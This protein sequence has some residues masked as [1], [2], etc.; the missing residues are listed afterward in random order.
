[1]E[2]A[3]GLHGRIFHV[4]IRRHVYRRAAPDP[5]DDVLTDAI[6]AFLG[7][8]GCPRTASAIDRASPAPIPI[9]FPPTSRRMDPAAR[10]RSILK[11]A[12]V[13]FA[14]HGTSGQMRELARHLGIAH[15]LLFHYFPSKQDLLD[16]V[17][18]EVFDR[19]WHAVDQTLLRDRRR[20]LGE[21]L[22]IFYRAYLAV[23]DRDEWIRIFIS[24][25][26]HDA[27]LC[28]R[29]LDRLEAHVID[30][31]V[32]E[33]GCA[34]EG[35]DGRDLREAAWGL[36]GQIVYRAIRHHIYAMPATVPSQIAI[37]TAASCFLVG[38]ERRNGRTRKAEGGP[39]Q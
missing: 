23:V 26:L 32:E 36:H 3:W 15:S 20:P 5:I 30:V 19:P 27:G 24:T 35:V 37:E 8:T 18:A 28:G 10:A 34:I 31:V 6:G 38:L 7:D 14:R 2:K 21:R 13:F 39:P 33:S 29:Y 16:Q 25:G 22:V 11:G 9:A 1:M 17:Y 4:A 12:V